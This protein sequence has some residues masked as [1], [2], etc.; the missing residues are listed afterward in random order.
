MS[1]SAKSGCSRGTRIILIIVTR[2]DATS[3]KILGQLVLGDPAPELFTLSSQR[4]EKI[5]NAIA[6]GLAIDYIHQFQSQYSN[7]GSSCIELS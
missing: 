6:Q 5:K 3:I 7:Y 1:I 4:Y 2:Y